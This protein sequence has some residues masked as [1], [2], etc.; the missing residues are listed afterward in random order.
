M[1]RPTIF[2]IITRRGIFAFVMLMMILIV[3]TPAVTIKVM[4]FQS[5]Q[6]L[7][8]KIIVIDPGHG[9]ID[10]GTHYEEV[11]LEKNINLAIGLKLKE[12]LI[13]KGATVFMTR[14]IDES[15]DDH[16][17]NGNRHREDLNARVKIINQNNPD[18]FVC[19]HTNYAKNENRVGPIVYYYGPSEKSR[20]LAEYLQTNL[21]NLSAYKEMN[22]IVNH[23][24]TAGNYYV[25]RNT[26][27]PGVIVETGFI[28]NN[29]DRSLLSEEDHQNEIVTRI[30]EGVIEYFSK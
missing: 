7:Q 17:N 21:N 13:K 24:A 11:I 19:I 14:E 25:L 23:S 16:I 6:G 10:G 3:L 9:G 2:F 12:E 5:N 26:S 20:S 18:L 22:L 8:G 4:R 1:K 28:S 27:P 29:V 30:M 15:L